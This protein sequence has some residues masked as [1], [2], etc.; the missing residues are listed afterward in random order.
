MPYIW[1]FKNVGGGDQYPYGF[2]ANALLT[3]HVP[4]LELNG[5]F[6]GP[7][8]QKL[9]YVYH[10]VPGAWHSTRLTKYTQR[11]PT[12]YTGENFLASSHRHQKALIK[13][14]PFAQD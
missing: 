11:A 4:S 10:C 3:G 14:F 6:Q 8:G 12:G 1:I 7:R 5:F 2:E 13:F 9:L